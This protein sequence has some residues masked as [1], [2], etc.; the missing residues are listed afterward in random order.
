ML[1]S[2]RKCEDVLWH[3][4]K[5]RECLAAFLEAIPQDVY[6]LPC[7]AAHSCVGSR[8]RRA[9]RKGRCHPSWSGLGAQ[10]AL[11]RE[12]LGTNA[13][14]SVALREHRRERST[15]FE[16]NHGPGRRHLGKRN[17]RLVNYG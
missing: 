1:R 9:R 5:D 17:G 13:T 15:F 12:R 3:P 7:A 2:R 11:D 10:R 14:M 8:R 4:V 6:Q 16:G